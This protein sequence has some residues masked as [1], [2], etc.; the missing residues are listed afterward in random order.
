[1]LVHCRAGQNRSANV[2]AGY[3]MTIKGITAK[4]AMNIIRKKKIETFRPQNFMSALRE[5]ET[6]LKN[7]GVIKTKTVLK[8]VKPVSKPQ[9]TVSTRRKI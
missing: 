3:L 6:T 5:Y 1:V 7:E 2:V 9:K 8:P 4:E